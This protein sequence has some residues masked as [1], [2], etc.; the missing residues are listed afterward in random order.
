MYIFLSKLSTGREKKAL[1]LLQKCI[2]LTC[3][4]PYICPAVYKSGQ[5]HWHMYRKLKSTTVCLIAKSF[6][7]CLAFRL[8]LFQEINFTTT[9]TEFGIDCQLNTVFCT[10]EAYI[11]SG[12][13]GWQVKAQRAESASL[14]SSK[15]GPTAKPDREST[16]PYSR[17]PFW[18]HWVPLRQKATLSL[19]SFHTIFLL[20]SR[21]FANQ[22]PRMS[23]REKSQSDYKWTNST[24]AFWK[25]NWK[26]WKRCPRG[27]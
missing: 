10:V 1:Q 3:T 16:S 25:T 11:L 6:S 21:R 27:F 13:S 24:W 2:L 15:T 5:T 17:D 8:W 14:Y 23:K 9:M 18:H 20:V 12:R 22:E 4:F 26:M 19:L 7:R